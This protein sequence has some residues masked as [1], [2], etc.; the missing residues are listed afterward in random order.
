MHKTRAK[1]E[2][3]MQAAPNVPRA[4]DIHHRVKCEAH[5]SPSVQMQ[6]AYANPYEAPFYNGKVYRRF[7]HPTHDPF[8]I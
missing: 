7:L 4:W 5:A 3:N 1:T 6:L 8:N 2:N